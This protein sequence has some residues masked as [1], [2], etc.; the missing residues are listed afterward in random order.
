M[1]TS[2]LTKLYT[3]LVHPLL[4]HSC[5]VWDPYFQKD[6]D[7]MESVQRLACKICTKD[8]SASYS[9]HLY[10]L[11]LPTSHYR[12]IFLKLCMMFKVVKNNFSFPES[13]HDWPQN[14]V[15][16]SLHVHLSCFYRFSIY[17]LCSPELHSFVPNTTSLWNDSLH[18][19]RRRKMTH[20]TPEGGGKWRR[21][22]EESFWLVRA[23]LI[24]LLMYAH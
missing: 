3:T 18:S 17:S 22:T 16:D 9:D 6:I 5:A 1:N 15:S 2:L 14:K 4:E 11:S 21:T 10:I 8:W 7:K 24:E 20:C 12:R 23:F 19:R 13:M